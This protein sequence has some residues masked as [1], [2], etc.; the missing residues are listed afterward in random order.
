MEPQSSTVSL[1]WSCAQH[2]SSS[3]LPTSDISD[4]SSVNSKLSC[5]ANSTD[6][7]TFASKPVVI[8]SDSG[9]FMD[10]SSSTSEQTGDAQASRSSS[11]QSVDRTDSC[12]DRPNSAVR[13]FGSNADRPASAVGRGVQIVDYPRW[14]P[15][16]HV[17]LNEES[18][19]L[20]EEYLCS[21][22]LVRHTV[23]WLF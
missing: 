11:A 22:K 8:S 20:M 17:S 19:V 4:S 15:K 12:V 2:V 9:I 10:R 21:R 3:T 13:C 6:L 5:F 1:T 23:H 14:N 7:A 18:L 16:P